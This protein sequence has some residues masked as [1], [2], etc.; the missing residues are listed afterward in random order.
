[1]ARRMSLRV[2][3]TKVTGRPTADAI[4]VRT[5]GSG[6]RATATSMP[7]G[8]SRTGMATSSRAM[9]SG[10]RARASRWGDWWRRSTTGTRCWAA[11]ADVA[12]LVDDDRPGRLGRRDHGLQDATAGRGLLVQLLGCGAESGARI[13]RCG[14]PRRESPRRGLRYGGSR[15]LASSRIH[16]GRTSGRATSGVAI[17]IC[18][19][20]PFPCSSSPSCRALRDLSTPHQGRTRSR[21]NQSAARECTIRPAG[22]VT[23]WAV[24]P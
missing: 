18:L 11:A 23:E 3:R 7:P 19:I 1:M 4:L 17:P 16:A 2:A 22:D 20:G 14:S 5:A 9:A 8:S 21:S 6:R 15:R 13:R 24:W 10:R 12:A